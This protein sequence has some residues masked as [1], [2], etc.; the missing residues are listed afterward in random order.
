MK[1]SL[2]V[3]ALA[4]VLGVSGCIGVTPDDRARDA[5]P[6][7]HEDE[8]PTHRAGQPCLLCHSAEGGQTPYFSIA[9]TVYAVDGVTGR[10]GV[11]VI[12]VDAAGTTFT[13]TTNYVG[14]FMITPDEWTPV[15]PL[16]ADVTDGDTSV[17]MRSPISREGSCSSCHT[18][19][20]SATSAGRV[21]VGV[22]P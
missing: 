6:D 9:G 5:L 8:G 7:D 17:E 11:Q 1:Q 10:G 15:F 2:R 22:F 16:T 21:V 14:N 12:L 20:R 18:A 19:T 4:F 3:A 13:A